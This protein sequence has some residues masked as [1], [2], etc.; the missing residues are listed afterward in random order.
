MKHT[1]PVTFQK[2]KSKDSSYTLNCEVVRGQAA[3][4]III[5]SILPDERPQKY[6]SKNDWFGIPI[7]IDD[8]ATPSILHQKIKTIT[9]FEIYREP[10]TI[11]KRTHY[12]TLA[13]TWL[14]RMSGTTV[15]I[16]LENGEIL[17]GNIEP[18]LEKY[19]SKIKQLE[20]E[21]K[22]AKLKQQ[23]IEHQVKDEKDLDA[24]LNGQKPKETVKP[25]NKYIF[26]RHDGVW[27]IRY[28]SEK[29]FFISPR[30]GFE[31]IRILLTNPYRKF[32]LKEIKNKINPPPPS[33]HNDNDIDKT[34]NE[35]GKM[36]PIYN[37]RKYAHLEEDILPSKESA[38]VK[39]ELKAME[40]ERDDP[41]TSMMRH[42]DLDEK[43]KQV[44][45]YLRNATDKAGKSRKFANDTERYRVAVTK[46][47][48]NAI[49][50]L[51]AE[52]KDFVQHL[53]CITKGSTLKY[54]PTPTINWL[55]EDM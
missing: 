37:I 14:E 27:E 53:S 42:E 34:K 12:S 26:R 28:E 25:E 40:R 52:L 44:Q 5:N 19:R 30:K 48:D 8:I 10:S 49:K 4:E 46:N 24:V 35:D 39:K 43:I 13:A 50:S 18:R 55:T 47:I 17:L 15:S 32:S 54:S 1:I 41:K 3:N 36:M 45:D 29:S 38:N 2:P 33:E 9:I 23:L 51:P 22:V 31:Y 16:E 7:L 6:R 20:H 11:S 21:Q